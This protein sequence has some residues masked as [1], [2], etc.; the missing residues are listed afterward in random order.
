MDSTQ[1]GHDLL[2]IPQDNRSDV[3][4][5]WRNHLALVRH[6]ARNRTRW[7][8]SLMKMLIWVLEFTGLIAALSGISALCLIIDILTSY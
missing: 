3:E 4:N 5:G 8:Y 1:H 6:V 2:P 7:I